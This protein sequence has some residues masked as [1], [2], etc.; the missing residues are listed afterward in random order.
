VG[1]LADRWGARRM[2]MLG[3]SLSSFA[4]AIA[5]Q[6]WSFVSAVA[7]Q[8]PLVVTM[9]LMIT[10]SLAYMG[11]ATSLS[12]ASSFGVA[13]GLYNMAWGVGLLGGPAVG[14]F[15]FERLGF[16]RLVLVWAPPLLLITWLLARVQSR[17]PHRGERMTGTRSITALTLS[18]LLLSSYS[19]R[20]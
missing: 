6:S 7:L 5:G 18:A 8:L 13:Y 14:G 11:E 3:L 17:S 12:G 15:L 20:A 16:S 4:L 19:V 2:M 9:A 10:P 1:H